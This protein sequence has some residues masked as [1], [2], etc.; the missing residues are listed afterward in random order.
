[1][2]YL[3]ALWLLS[4]CGL[5]MACSG[6]DEP[7]SLEAIKS[8]QELVIATRNSPTNRYIDREG[9]AAGPENDLAAAFARHLGVTPRFIVAESVDEVLSLVAKGQVD[10]AAA[11]ITRTPEREKRFVFGPAY[12][13]VSQQVVCNNKNKPR[14]VDDL[15]QV[16][17]L[18]VGAGTSY[19]AL[20]GRLAQQHPKLELHWKTLADVSTEQLLAQVADYRIGCT[21]ADSNIVAINRRYYPS[22]LM[23]FNISEPQP[24]AWPLPKGADELR[25]ALVDWFKGFKESGKLKEL[26]D[27]Y[28]GYI[29]KWNFVDKNTLMKRIETVYPQYDALFAEAAERY[30]FDKWLLAAQAYQESHW[31]PKATSYTGV[32]G[33]MMLTQNT[34]ES[35]GVTNRLDPEQSIMGGARYLRKMESKL[36]EEIQPPERYYFALAAY[37]IGFYHLR[38]AMTLAKR[39]GRDPHDWSDVEKTLPLLMQRR[40]YKDLRYGYA[41]GAEA[42]RYVQ[43][44]RDYGDIIQQVMSR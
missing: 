33:I 9:H 23:M 38:D 32:R 3:K 39:L 6:L 21:L 18:V 11:S 12:A 24:L 42:V 26:E 28:Y 25:Q 19:D 35:L 13:H 8:R 14:G 20:L 31:D 44:I 16:S 15:P 40:Y 10:M 17:E 41:R 5:L 7:G 27:R 34:A 2:R 37:N 22:L 1:M 43:R 30:G 4:L 29:G 36:P